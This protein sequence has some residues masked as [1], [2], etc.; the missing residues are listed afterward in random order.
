[1]RRTLVYSVAAILTC[2]V[3]AWAA[4][5]PPAATEPGV[6]SAPATQPARIT[7]LPAAAWL[8]TD[9]PVQ[10]E[11]LQGRLWVLGV[12]EPW[13]TQSHKAASMLAHVEKIW[14]PRGLSA[15]L[16]TV[17]SAEQAKQDLADAD[18]PLPIGTGSAL[19][20]LLPL[21]PLPQVY[22]IGPEQQVVWAGP[23]WHL[24]GILPEQYRTLTDNGLSPTRTNEL[25]NRLNRARAAWE[26]KEYFL[27]VGLA[28]IVADAAP[29]N[30]P[31]HNQAAELL[32]DLDRTGQ[33][34]LARAQELIRQKR[35]AEGY[36][37]LQTVAEQF[38]GTRSGQAAL[39]AAR[40]FQ[41]NDRQWADVI[42]QR[43]RESA[44]RTLDLA[45]RAIAE[46]RYAEAQRYYRR[47]V[48]LYP[49]TESAV[50][51]RQ[52]LNQFRKDKALATQLAK[53]QAEPAGPVLLS[54]AARY[55]QMG[56]YDQARQYYQQVL[57]QAAGTPYADQA[58]Q[59]LHD[60]PTAPATQPN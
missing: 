7:G 29:V 24:E 48:E 59:A 53:Q 5:E 35:S 13:S 17:Q 28:S 60:L 25:T 23:V 9:K 32:D 31:L 4:D 55:A 26:H 51:A 33:E 50:Q 52:G 19:P 1:M 15:F 40:Q 18:I 6:T 56:R 54:L 39:H 41:A 11:N 38:Y 21:E 10:V 37:L 16:L 58:R 30:H 12:I 2:V 49:R 42:R 36:D 14:G 43:D 3:P 47:I 27:A 46:Q 45:E 8:N 22:L 57:R 20:L 34:M 44:R